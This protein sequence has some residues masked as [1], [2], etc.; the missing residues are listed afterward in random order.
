MTDHWS[1]EHFPSKIEH[2]TL[3]IRILR[4][5]H[6]PVTD[7]PDQM[8]DLSLSDAVIKEKRFVPADDH[9]SIQPLWPLPWLSCSFRQ[10]SAN[11]LLL[12]P[13]GF[14]SLFN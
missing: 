10:V 9:D 3:T 8:I 13:G 5:S 4:N 2:E 11:M 6:R 1:K 14:N 7:S 12:L